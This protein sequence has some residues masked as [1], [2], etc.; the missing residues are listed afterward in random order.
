MISTRYGPDVDRSLW[1]EVQSLR[2]IGS[3][4]YHRGWSMGT[5]SNYSMVRRRQPFELLITA[6][7][8]DK[9]QLTDQDF[10]LVDDQGR[11]VLSSD[12]KPSAETL[13]HTVLA[14]DPEVG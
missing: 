3:M 12:P 7:G 10:V 6:S 8:K 5:S 2:Q 4:F 9:G 11:P 14:Q 1:P 13:L